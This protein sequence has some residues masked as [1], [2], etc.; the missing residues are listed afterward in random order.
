MG[1][2]DSEPIPDEVAAERDD[3]ALCRKVVPDRILTQVSPIGGNVEA[4]L[5]VSLPLAGTWCKTEV[6]SGLGLGPFLLHQW[7]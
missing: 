3:C 1:N 5:D 2:V 7:Q 6:S 4:A